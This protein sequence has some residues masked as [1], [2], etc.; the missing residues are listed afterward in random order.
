MR[1]AI[2]NDNGMVN[3]HFGQSKEFVIIEMSGQE[4]KDKK[5]VS[6]AELAHNH[7]GLA[8]LLENE[9]V[10]AAIL[11]GIGPY[12]L[13][14]LREKGFKVITGISGNIEDVARTYAKGELVSRNVV[15]NHSGHGHGHSHG[16]GCSH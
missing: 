12:A 13:E 15:C 4:I 10:E 9:K 6:A 5:I 1:L 7:S 16:G 11:G 14:A 8:G 3:Q 2:P